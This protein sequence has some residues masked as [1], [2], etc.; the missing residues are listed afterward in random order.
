LRI[1]SRRKF[2]RRS[3]GPHSQNNL[4]VSDR[5]LWADRNSDRRTSPRM[6]GAIPM[7]LSFQADAQRE[8]R[9]VGLEISTQGLR[10]RTESEFPIGASCNL[11]LY[12]PE[13][14][15][16]L[17]VIGQIRWRKFDS[18]TKTYLYGLAFKNIPAEVASE[19][20]FYVDKNLRKHTSWPSKLSQV[21]YTKLLKSLLV[22]SAIGRQGIVNGK[23][24]SGLTFDHIYSGK[25]KGVGYIG[26]FVDKVLLNLPAAKA[27]RYRKELIR[28]ALKYEIK[29]NCV[30]G[31]LTR[32][33]DLG[34]GA[35]RYLIESIGVKEM[36][37]VQALCLD[38]D[39]E[40]VTFGRKM[41]SGR[42]IRFMKY[43]VFKTQRLKSLARKIGWRPNVI[44]V[45]GLIY[46]FS[47]DKVK[48]LL[49]QIYGWLEPGGVLI[50]SNMVKNP[51]KKLIGRLFI[52]GNGDQWIPLSRPTYI[53]RNW[54]IDAGFNISKYAQDPWGMYNVFSAQKP[55]E[56]IK[57]SQM[58]VLTEGGILRGKM[59]IPNSER[60]MK[61]I[62]L[63]VHG[64]GYTYSSYKLDPKI[65]ANADFA[66]CLYNMRG[67][68]SSEGEWDLSSSINDVR[69]VIQTLI[70][71]YGNDVP[72][73]LFA[74]STGALIALLASLKDH[75][76]SGASVVN[77]VNS[78]TDSY[79][80]WHQSDYHKT[81]K[82]VFKMEGKVPAIINEFLDD[83]EVMKSYRKDSTLWEK[84]EFPFRYGLLRSNSFANL[85]RAICYSPDIF[86]QVDKLRFPIIFFSGESDEAI[87]TSTTEALFKRIHG[88]KKI[89]KTD[90]KKHFQ[91]DRWDVIQA[92]TVAYFREL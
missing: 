36:A 71:R 5:R 49:S 57:I 17:Q 86:D 2:Q 24:D 44:V 23:S 74:H 15:L 90:S 37:H 69:V 28:E 64:L 34:A 38:R 50:I 35:S 1:V 84:L 76:I 19:L 7:H 4:R 77:I 62:V 58:E 54:L 6:H 20:Q 87:S 85:A 40:V 65:F 67:H 25:A 72:I 61:G 16:P 13:L 80:H 27:S 83:I 88:R 63:F 43:D 14:F 73:F 89:I 9:E 33:L 39:S 79:L 41:A 47:D 78:V 3:V 29:R 30:D 82:E 66:L 26:R 31:H 11:C 92:E 68:S 32:I 48:N 70:E 55:A 42:P 21:I 60:K 22:H 45:S 75:R 59:M 81:V 91:N 53:V 56:E 46:Y 8:F 12:P 51:N 18:K 10:I 52:T